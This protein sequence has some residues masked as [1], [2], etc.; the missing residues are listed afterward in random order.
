MLV[1]PWLLYGPPPP[2]APGRRPPPPPVDPLK[3]V[4]GQI[5]FAKVQLVDEDNKL[6][7]PTSLKLILKTFDHNV[8][9][10][11]LVQVDPPVVKILNIEDEKTREREHEAKL[12]LSRRIAFEDKEL[13]VPWHAAVGDLQHKANTARSL[14][15]KGDRVHLVFARRAGGGQRQIITDADKEKIVALFAEALSPIASR[16]REDDRTRKAI[17]VSYWQPLEAIRT[18]VRKKI[19]D[20]IVE[21]RVASLDK[22]EERRLREQEKQ[23]KAAER[24]KAKGL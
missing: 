24:A 4:N 16:W 6:G 18:E 12:R 14:L 2:T 23:R 13:Q 10:L 7:D 8:D 20:G 5:P 22:K 3:L 11:R 21:K 1:D 17:W 19:L 15:E 9:V